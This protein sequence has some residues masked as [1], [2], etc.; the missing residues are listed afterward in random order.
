MDWLDRL[1]GHIAHELDVP[2]AALK[3]PVRQLRPR[4]R[5]VHRQSIRWARARA[6]HRARMHACIDVT[7]VHDAEKRFVWARPGEL[8]NVG[9]LTGAVDRVKWEEKQ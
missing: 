7:T 5:T 6:A 4:P 9:P 3:R 1:I 8:V 2:V